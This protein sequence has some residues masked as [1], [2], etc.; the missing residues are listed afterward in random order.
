MTVTH[1]KITPGYY[2]HS[3]NLAGNG[4]VAAEYG[5]FIDGE[6]VY[7]IRQTRRAN[8]SND[9]TWA[10]FTPEGRTTTIPHKRTLKAMR[11]RIERFIAK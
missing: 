6:L 1:K 3:D 8:W 9:A 5:V 7:L 11:E 4:Q 10:A 2:I